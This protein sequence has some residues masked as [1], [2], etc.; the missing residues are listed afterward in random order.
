MV[1]STPPRRGALYVMSVGLA[2][3]AC[4]AE[5]RQA[6][7]RTAGDAPSGDVQDRE[8]SIG[9]RFAEGLVK[10]FV[11]VPQTAA[12][13]IQAMEAAALRPASYAPP[14]NLRKDVTVTNAVVEGWPVYTVSPK[15]GRPRKALVYLHGGAFYGEI[16]DFQWNLAARIA[17][18]T[19]SE[20][21]VP[22]YP[23]APRG[24]AQDVVDKVAII[25]ASEI[26]RF[27]EGTVS[28]GGDSAGGTIALAA[29]LVLRDRGERLRETVLIHPA[30]DL[31]LTNPEIAEVQRV[32]PILRAAA[33]RP[34]VQRWAGNLDIQDPRVSPLYGNMSG[35]GPMTIFS[36]TH[37]STDPDTR[38]L[39]AKARA[40]G[41]TVAYHEGVGLI[42]VSPA[43]D[44]PEGKEARRQIV[45]ALN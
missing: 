19:G 29:A 34:I 22:I 1:K 32:D 16:T 28:I 23:L 17:A 9:S 27:G 4:A 2:L 42:H 18:E 15:N 30:V 20:V 7:I 12:E 45:E 39:V 21:I 6:S 40:A 31:S 10:T 37:D 36:G 11:K 33:L 8:P 43:L 14:K 44:T 26:K 5:P 38:L 24:T 13:G 35:L 25:T 3:S 41:V